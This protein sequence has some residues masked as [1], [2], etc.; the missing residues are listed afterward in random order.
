MIAF[1]ESSN[2]AIKTS[3]ARFQA[4][5]SISPATRILKKWNQKS[6]QKDIR[7][8]GSNILTKRLKERKQNACT[9]GI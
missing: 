5:A 9:K 4:M 8:M 1:N 7:T 3:L 2:N 6:T